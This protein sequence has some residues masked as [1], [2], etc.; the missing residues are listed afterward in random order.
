MSD[1]DTACH[2]LG[3]VLL[4]EIVVRAG[5]S[6]T[7]TNDMEVSLAF[8]VAANP[9]DDDVVVRYERVGGATVEIHLRIA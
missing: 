4:E 7:L 9:E 5:L 1:V 2:A 3:E 8:T 6:R